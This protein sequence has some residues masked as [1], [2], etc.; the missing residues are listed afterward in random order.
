MII[1]VE[2]GLMLCDF[3]SLKV[4]AYQPKSLAFIKDDE[5]WLMGKIVLN[6]YLYNGEKLVLRAFDTVELAIETL[7]AIYKSIPNA[8]SLCPH[9]IPSQEDVIE[10]AMR[11]MG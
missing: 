2:T 9:D 1:K 7:N 5:K 11:N 8:I 10:T 4:E 3:Q 6:G